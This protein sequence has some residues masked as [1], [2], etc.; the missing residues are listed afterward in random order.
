ME[1]FPSENTPDYST[2]EGQSKWLADDIEFLESEKKKA[3]E[4]GDVEYA[5]KNEAYIAADKMQAEQVNRDL[6]EQAEVKASLA[7]VASEEARSE[8]NEEAKIPYTS[9][10]GWGGEP[11]ML[12]QEEYEARKEADKDL[13]G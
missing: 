12:T 3:E 5:K 7:D 6:K 13:V 10:Y 1:K 2:P 4:S 8:A 11:E 9:P